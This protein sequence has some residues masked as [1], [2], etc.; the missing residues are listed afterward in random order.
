MMQKMA[1][2]RK[3]VE[4]GDH[5]RRQLRNQVQMLSQMRGALHGPCLV[6]VRGCW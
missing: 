2:L 6:V 5:Q 1:T 4:L 3:A